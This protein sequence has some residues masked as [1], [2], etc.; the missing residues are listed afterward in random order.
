ME[1]KDTVEMMVSDDYRKRFRAEYAQLLIR[2]DKLSRFIHSI[3]E[4]RANGE[5]EPAHDCPMHIL[6]RQRQ[7][8]MDYLRILAE[9]AA[10]EGVSLDLGE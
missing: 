4:A 7:I 8:M 5:P 6:C 1:L 2:T 9:R 3:D 10:L